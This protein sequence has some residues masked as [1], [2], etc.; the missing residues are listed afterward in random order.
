MPEA[1]PRSRAQARSL[2]KRKPVKVP[3][4]PKPAE[5]IRH[6]RIRLLKQQPPI[7]AEPAVTDRLLTKRELLDR[8]GIS[9]PKIW[10]LMR[11]GT[12]PRSRAI[13]G[14]LV[15]L[16]SEINEWIRALPKTALKGDE[17]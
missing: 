4:L 16:E 8:V 15:W 11:A 14:K 13:G 3:P 7:P 2:K 12:F 17:E 5:P 6:K 9:Y 10:M 1:E